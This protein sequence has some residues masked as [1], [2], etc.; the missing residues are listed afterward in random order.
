MIRTLVARTYIHNLVIHQMDINTTFLNGDVDEE[1]YM[2]QHE[3]YVVKDND[4]MC[5]S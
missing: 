5:F 4:I 1:I 3:G 2:E